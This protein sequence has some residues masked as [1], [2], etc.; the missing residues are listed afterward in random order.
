MTIDE[1]TID[2][3]AQK[4]HREAD[5][6]CIAG[7]ALAV[8]AVTSAAVSAH[9]AFRAYTDK[10]SGNAALYNYA[11]FGIALGCAILAKHFYTLAKQ[12]HTNAENYKPWARK[13]AENC[14]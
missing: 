2:A 6:L 4:Q 10:D 13:D 8:P 3:E 9:E 1:N 5:K 12:W 7:T 11:S 14:K